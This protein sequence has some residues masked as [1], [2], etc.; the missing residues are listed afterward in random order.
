MSILFIRLAKSC[1][2]FFALVF[3][4]TTLSINV[5]AVVINTPIKKCDVK[6]P[7]ITISSM[8]N[9]GTFLPIVPENCAKDA[10]GSAIFI[11][12]SFLPSLM[13]RGYGF[14][15]SLIF[16]SFT[17]IIIF[18]GIIKMLSATDFAIKEFNANKIA[19][20]ATIGLIIA[21]LAYAGVFTILAIIRVKPEITGANL[22]SFFSF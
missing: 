19:E 21:F 6:T 20:N 22:D 7:K 2:K 16:Y 4:L 12:P 3:V 10:N 11:S 17:P 15:V 14:L 9:L 13:L 1:L 8:L 18:A 5:M